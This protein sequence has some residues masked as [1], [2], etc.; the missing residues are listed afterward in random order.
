MIILD[1]NIWISSL[2]QDDSNHK[3]AKDLIL[4]F[5]KDKIII[6]DYILLEIATVLSKKKGKKIADDFIN[7]A[8]NN[9]NIEI[10]PYSSNVF[11][12]L[13]DFYLKQENKNISFVDYSLIYFSKKY[14][15][16]VETFDKILKNSLKII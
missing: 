7:I 3:K 10:W 5:Q 11:Y 16:K 4:S 8:L 14:N 6:T 12:E 13:V 2:D 9:E 1:S 15:V